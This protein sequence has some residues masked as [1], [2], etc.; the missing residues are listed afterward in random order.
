MFER[1][2]TLLESALMKTM[3]VSTILFWWL[4]IGFTDPP[5]IVGK[6]FDSAADW[7]RRR[8]PS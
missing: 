8:K 6:P 4:A 2:S 3:L 5:D 7:R 1:P